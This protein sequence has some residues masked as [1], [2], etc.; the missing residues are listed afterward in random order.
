MRRIAGPAG[1]GLHR[2]AW[3]LRYARSMPV[4]QGDEDD[5]WDDNGS[6]MAVLPGTYTVQLSQYVD[7]E[8]SA[9]TQPRSFEVAALGRQSLPVNRR[10]KFNFESLSA[11]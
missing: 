11:T 2:V 10:A 5:P 4:T 1:S 8:F 9:L 7:G 6:G 3:D